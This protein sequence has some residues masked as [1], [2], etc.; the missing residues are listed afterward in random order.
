MGFV[1]FALILALLTA[2]FAPQNS[3]L[4]PFSPIEASRNSRPEWC[5]AFCLTCKQTAH[6][7]IAF[8]QLDLGMRCQDRPSA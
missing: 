1:F 3:D 8:F 7:K 6:R 5:G 4:T 2:A